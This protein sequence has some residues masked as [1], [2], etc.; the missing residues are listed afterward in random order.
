MSFVISAPTSS[1][2]QMRV[3]QSVFFLGQRSGALPFGREALKRLGGAEVLVE[4]KKNA[5]TFPEEKIVIPVGVTPQNLKVS[6]QRNVL[7]DFHCK[8]KCP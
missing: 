7:K 1:S 4:S 6:L 8:L 3:V 5:S 2:A